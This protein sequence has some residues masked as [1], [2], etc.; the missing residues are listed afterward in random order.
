MNVVDEKMGNEH[1]FPLPPSHQAAS[2]LARSLTE[3]TA[4]FPGVALSGT[5]TLG[6]PVSISS[7]PAQQT[8]ANQAAP[9]RQQVSPPQEHSRERLQ[10]RS[11][12]SNLLFSR[13]SHQKH[14]PNFSDVRTLFS[15]VKTVFNRRDAPTRAIP[16]KSRPRTPT[17]KERNRAPRRRESFDTLTLALDDD[18]IIAAYLRLCPPTCPTAT[19]KEKTQPCP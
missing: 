4:A 2:F 5:P 14:R 1:T 12:P 6:K 11:L 18:C 15:T 19:S 7:C 17:T 16:R 13:P 9:K 3:P 8:Q 10:A